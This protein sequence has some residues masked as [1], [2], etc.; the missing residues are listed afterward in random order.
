[1]TRVR[2]IMTTNPLYAETSETVTHAARTM[3]DKGVGAL[4]IRG[5]DHKLKG[6]LTDRD[7]VVKVLAEGKDPVAVHVGE[8]PRDE[9]VAVGPD[10]DVEEALRLMSRHQVRRLPVVEHEELVGMVAQADVARELPDAEVG[11]TVEGIS[12]D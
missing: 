12:R 5:E 10:D 4:P 3:A 11:E 7:I 6:M 8:L 1:M 2:E 9:V